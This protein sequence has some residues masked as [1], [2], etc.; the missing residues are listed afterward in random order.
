MNRIYLIGLILLSLGS[1]R[2]ES[3][4]IDSTEKSSTSPILP[5]I[6]DRMSLV[7]GISAPLDHGRGYPKGFGYFLWKRNAWPWTST[8]FRLVFA[9]V[10]GDAELTMRSLITENTDFGLGFHSQTMGRLE[11]YDRGQIPIGNRIGISSYAGRLFVQQ[12]LIVNYVEIA[13]VRASY[14]S[15]Y[16]QY[17]HL[18][19]TSSNFRVAR[20]GL[21]Q[22][23][24]LD[25]DA[26]SVNHSNYSPSGWDFYLGFEA[27]FRDHWNSWGHPNSW[28]SPSNFQ[29]M[30]MGGAY[31][32]S[33]FADQ[34]LVTKLATGTGNG[35]DRLSAYKLGGS[36]EDLP[37]PLSLHGFY[38]REIFAK[39]FGLLNLDYVIPML[40]QQELSMHLY[41]DGA[42]TRRADIPDQEPHGWAGCGTGVS[43]QGWWETQWLIGYGYGINAQRGT[44]HGGHEIFARLS[45]SF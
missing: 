8:D 36:L 41:A 19:E 31:V 28:D 23:I 33:T 9:G 32:F 43:F 30:K 17:Y 38:V 3:S 13:R 5:R 44:S 22:S 4:S 34:K 29:K 24:Q 27:T 45:K 25:G 20:S 39:D 40:K 42:I 6:H 12:H 14:V 21:F 37:H 35:I 2:A 26:G 10:G 16:N 1:L 11:E 15:G 7:S 18:N